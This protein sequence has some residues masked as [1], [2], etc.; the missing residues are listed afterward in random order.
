MHIHIFGCRLKV[1]STECSIG[2]GSKQ[3]LAE[4]MEKLVVQEFGL[5]IICIIMRQVGKAS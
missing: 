5:Q 1:K 4:K 2:V 3:A